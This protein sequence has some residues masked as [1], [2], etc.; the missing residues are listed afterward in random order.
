[1]EKTNKFQ[2]K[3]QKL[4]LKWKSLSSFWKVALLSACLI[5]ISVVIGIVNII[6]SPNN[7]DLTAEQTAYE[8]ITTYY[9][10]ILQNHGL[11]KAETLEVKK[12]EV[13][14]L[15]DADFYMKYGWFYLKVN[16]IDCYYY[17]QL[18]T[19]G[20]STCTL[21]SPNNAKNWDFTPAT[22]V[23]ALNTKLKEFVQKR[24]NSE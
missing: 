23:R 22:S 18:D 24:T 20:S 8:L 15:L 16:N 2:N 11:E 4:L 3:M 14:Y 5:I 6:I 21:T 9:D 19:E 1:M 13:N 12:C 17:L 7:G 10:N